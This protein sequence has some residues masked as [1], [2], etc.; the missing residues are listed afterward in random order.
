[1][2]IIERTSLL[3]PLGRTLVPIDPLSERPPV[4]FSISNKQR[5]GDFRD[6]APGIDLPSPHWLLARSLHYADVQ[7]SH[8]PLEYDFHCGLQNRANKV[9]MD[10]VKKQKEGFQ[11][12]SSQDKDGVEK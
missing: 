8:E 5:A 12:D 9:H 2:I 7:R 1:M 3:N 6:F 10:C 4:V 11:F